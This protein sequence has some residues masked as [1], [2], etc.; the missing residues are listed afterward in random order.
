MKLPFY[1]HTAMIFTSILSLLRYYDL[2][3]DMF[4]NSVYIVKALYIIMGKGCHIH[5]VSLHLLNAFS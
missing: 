3:E 5:S 1:Y 2:H 4:Y